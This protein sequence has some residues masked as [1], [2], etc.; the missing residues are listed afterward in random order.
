MI[1]TCGLKPAAGK[2][3]RDLMAWGG[4]ADRWNLGPQTS[5]AQNSARQFC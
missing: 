5:Q 1:L 2:F 3:M 4:I